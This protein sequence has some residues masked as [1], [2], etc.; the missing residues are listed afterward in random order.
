M[1]QQQADEFIAEAMEKLNAMQEKYDARILAAVCMSKAQ[2]LYRNLRQLGLETPDS[3]TAIF[4]YALNGSLQDGTPA[5]VV[6]EDGQ[7]ISVSRN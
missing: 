6:S 5:T 7:V 2:F 3:L 4:E 1:N